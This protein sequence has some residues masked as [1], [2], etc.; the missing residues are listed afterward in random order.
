MVAFLKTYFVT[1]VSLLAAGLSFFFSPAEAW[2]Q[3][4]DWTT[5]NLLFCLMFVVA[6]LRSCNFF[7][8][9][10]QRILEGCQSY[11]ALAHLLV[12]LTFFLSMLMTND[13]ALIALV[14]FAIYL[15]NQLGLQHRLPTLVVLQTL[16]A[17]MGSMATPIGNPQNLFLYMAYDLSPGTFFSAMLPLT[18]LGGLL[19]AA[20]TQ[21]LKNEP[22]HVVFP[23]RRTLKRPQ[24]VGVYGVLF[25]L[26][27]LSVFRLLPGSWLF[28][29]VVGSAVLWSRALFR[30]V[31]YGL[32]LTFVGFFIFSG[33]LGQIPAVSEGLT[34]LLAG[35]TQSTA[36]VASQVFS[37]VPAAILLEPFT[38]DWKALLFGVDIG[39]FG[40]PI[41]SLAS[42]IAMSFYLRE[43]HARLGY[44]L[45]LFTVFN[46]IVL[47]G[48]VLAA[49]LL[50]VL[51]WIG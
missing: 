1:L 49:K 26:C 27:L 41:A 13:V 19:L 16:A 47:A 33:N 20:L 28:G 22:I 38:A 24:M 50:E 15:L 2:W 11:R 29:I 18:F 34:R 43:P 10:A 3:A 17:N 9:M 25:G 32:L 5:L 36:I 46:V 44:Y 31:D 42:L 14:P 23:Y 30:T 21:F 12:Q 7:R 35:H 45:A 51:P 39:G 6:G 37:N 8:V 4:I 48:L 40:T